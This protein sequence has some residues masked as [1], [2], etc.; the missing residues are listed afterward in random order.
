MIGFVLQLPPICS[1][2]EP[3]AMSGRVSPIGPAGPS[4]WREGVF[5]KPAARGT[6]GPDTHVRSITA[7]LGHLS[8]QGG[9]PNP[10]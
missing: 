1:R 3:M 7:A 4:A 5:I 6:P 9:R 8:S 2:N 10:R